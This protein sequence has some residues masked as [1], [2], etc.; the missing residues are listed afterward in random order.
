MAHNRKHRG[1]KSIIRAEKERERRIVTVV[2]ALALIVIM[3]AS[4]FGVYQSIKST[5]NQNIES[6]VLK[7][8]IVDQLS[9]SIPNQTFIET[10]TKILK[11]ANY[12]IDYY[13]GEKVTVEFYRNLPTHEYKIII[14]RVHSSAAELQGEEFIET[15]V[16][17][18]TSEPYSQTKYIY[19]QLTDQLVI[20]SYTMPQPPYYFAIVPKFV[21]STMKGIFQDTVTIMMGC[22]GL[23]N[24]KMAEVFIQKGAKA[25]IGWKG[26]V[27]ASHTDAATT[28]LL[29]HLITHKQT[30]KQAVENTNK[31]AGP[32]PA[33]NS[34]LAYYPPTTA[35]QTI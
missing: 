17:F 30:I 2:M 32:D 23:N 19:E 18:F 13:P 31:E 29:Q 34:V 28:I 5:S 11:Q 25:Y 4:S 9:L 6:K 35:D 21:T 10:A 7:A 16:S 3:V 8:A 14:L 27:S 15:P 33:C 20:A 12:T 26:S 24:T 1:T 22:E